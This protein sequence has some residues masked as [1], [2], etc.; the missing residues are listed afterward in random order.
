MGNA[1]TALTQ[2]ASDHGGPDGLRDHYRDLGRAEG[3]K[4]AATY[5]AFAAAGTG[6]AYVV[7]KYRKRVADKELADRVA[8]LEA[9]DTPAGS[10][11]RP[12]SI[13][14]VLAPRPDRV[15]AGDGVVREK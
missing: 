13:T 11:Q 14:V 15:H 2:E 10:E 6:V 12:D 7:N 5:V 8:E 9:E 4:Q 1:W 3:L